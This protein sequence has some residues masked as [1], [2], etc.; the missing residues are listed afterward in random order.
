[1]PGHNL[2]NCFHQFSFQATIVIFRVENNKRR[3]ENRDHRIIVSRQWQCKQIEFR[4][5][6]RCFDDIDTVQYCL[7]RSYTCWHTRKSLLPSLLSLLL[8]YILKASRKARKVSFC[9]MIRSNA[10]LTVIFV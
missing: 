2:E 1:M 3:C 7:G 4:Y 5:Q 6:F 8:N 9:R 10:K